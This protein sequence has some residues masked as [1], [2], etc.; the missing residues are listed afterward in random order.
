[1]RPHPAGPTHF[2]PALSVLQRRSPRCAL[3]VPRSACAQCFKPLLVGYFLRLLVY[4]LA[5]LGTAEEGKSAWSVDPRIV[6]T[7]RSFEARLE[8]IRKRHECVLTTLITIIDS[9]LT[10]FMFTASSTRT[11]TN[12]TVRIARMSSVHVPSALRSARHG[13]FTISRGQ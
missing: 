2:Q 13:A 3:V 4:R 1:M 9:V 7:L 10:T 11:T 8:K 12:G 5:R 6:N